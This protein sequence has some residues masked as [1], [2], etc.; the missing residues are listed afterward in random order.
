MVVGP[1]PGIFLWGGGALDGNCLVGFLG[2]S[3]D[4]M[5]FNGDFMGISWDLVVV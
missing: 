3:W 2:I 5:G 4:F 1:R